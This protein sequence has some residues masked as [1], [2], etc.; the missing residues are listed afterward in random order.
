MTMKKYELV[1]DDQIT[2]FG[3]NLFRIKACIDFT[4]RLGE[5]IYKGDLGGFVENESNLS[6]NGSCWIFDDAMVFD[7]AKV[8]DSAEVYDSAWVYSHAKVCG[9]AI[10]FGSAEVYDEIISNGIRK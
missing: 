3:K 5:K 10:V 6:Q 4:T 7:N 8:S 9:N 1:K 2:V